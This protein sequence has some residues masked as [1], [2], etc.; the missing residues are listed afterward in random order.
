MSEVMAAKH[1][2]FDTFDCNIY[3]DLYPTWTNTVFSFGNNT[4]S[5][6]IYY[7]Y[8]AILSV[9]YDAVKSVYLIIY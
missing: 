7:R 2:G 1:I 5:F 4:F 6:T 9:M 8:H 3:S